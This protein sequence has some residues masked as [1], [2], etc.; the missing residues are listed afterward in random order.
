MGVIE[1]IRR[2]HDHPGIGDGPDRDH[3][4]AVGVRATRLAV[5]ETEV[6]VDVILLDLVAT[7]IVIGTAGEVT[8]IASA[9]RQGDEGGAT[10]LTVFPTSTGGWSTIRAFHLVIS[11]SI[12]A[13]CS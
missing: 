8:I 1:D 2:A 10:P 6:A 13:P 9:V 7:M 11:R 12:A 3:P 4:T 5:V